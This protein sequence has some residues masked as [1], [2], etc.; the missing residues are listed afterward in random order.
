MA[1]TWTLSGTNAGLNQF[2]TYSFDVQASE[3]NQVRIRFLNDAYN[4]DINYDRNVLLDS[5]TLNGVTY[6]ANADNVFVAGVDVVG[7][8]ISNGYLQSNRVATNGFWEFNST[9]KEVGSFI[10]LNVSGNTGDEEGLLLINGEAVKHFG[11]IPQSG[12]TV[13]Y[14]SE[15]PVSIDQLRVAF[16]ND[17][18]S[19]TYDRNLQ[20]NRLVLDGTVYTA[21][22]PQVF[23]TGY[24]IEGRGVVS[25][26]FQTNRLFANGYFQFRTSDNP[27]DP[28]PSSSLEQGLIGFWTLDEPDAGKQQTDFS[29]NGNAAT[30]VNVT[31]P[32]GPTTDKATSSDRNGGSFRF[33]GIDDGLS[34]STNSS[35][36]LSSGRYTQALWV[37]P[38]SG[39]DVYRGIIGFQPD[40]LAGGRYPFI[41]QKGTALYAGFGT[42]GDTWK[43]VIANNV[44]PIGQWSHVAVTFDGSEMELYVN[45]K[46]VAF[47]SSFAGSLPTTSVSQLSIG[48]I[49]TAFAGSVDEVRLYN[50]ALTEGEVSQL[51]A[52]YLGPDDSPPPSDNQSSGSIGFAKT[53]QTV[54][55]S[56]GSVSVTFTRI[57]GARGAAKA[58]F[59]TEDNSAIEG[60]DYIGQS[61]GVVEFADGQTESTVTIPIFD[62]D[63]R[64]GDRFFQ[65][66]MFRVEGAAQGQPRTSIVT[67]VDNESG[68]GLIGRWRLDDSNA[69]GSIVDSSG[70]ALNGTG[71]GFTA[72]NGASSDAPNTASGNGGS[73]RF[74]GINDAISIGPSESL[75]L[76]SGRYS[77]SLWIKPTHNDNEF[78]GIIG[79]QQ[80][81]S[82][83]TRYPFVYIRGDALYA[84]FGTGGNTWKGVVSGNVVTRNA[85]NHI[86]VTFDGSTMILFVN[87]EEVGRN[88]DFGGSVP[89]TQLA[90]LDIGRIN[91]Q[92][93]GAIDD[94]QLYD[95]A[96]SGSEVQNLID[97]ATLPPPRFSGFF[98]AQP[99]A[100]GLREPTGLERLPDGRF[101]AS[102]RA[103]TIRVINTDGSV[104]SRP[105]LDISS[106]VNRVGADR[107]I[108]AIAIPPDFATTRQLYVAYT[109]DPPE[110]QG[111]SGDG[112]PDGEGGRVARLSRFTL[113]EDFT[114]ADPNSEVVVLG[115]NSLYQY[116]G[117]PNR[118]PLLN[119]PKSGVDANGNYIED[120]IA[121]DELSHTIGDIEFGADGSLYVA[122]GDGG[123]YGRV[124]PVNLRALD[125]NSLN[126]KILRI[127]PNTGQGLADNPFYDGNPNSNRSRVYSLGLRNP[128][129]FAVQPQTNEI[130]ISDVGWL[131]WEEI[132]TGRGKNF[133][134]PVFEGNGPTGGSRGS[135]GSLPEVQQY[136]ATNPN[137]TGPLWTRSHSSGARAIIMGDFVSGGSYPASLQGAFL[138]TDIGDQVLRAG[139]LDASGKLI[140]VIPVSAKIGFI[141]D[142]M[143]MPDGSLYYTDLVAGTLGRLVYNA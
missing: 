9:R 1:A 104:N 127:D 95:R 133:G 27:T 85:W 31:A 70:N 131:N 130:Y 11:P 48:R 23:T 100:R 26:N 90:Q 29:G 102:E 54:N 123:S 86:A 78:R 8:G 115:K 58:F 97:G 89:T 32:A 106:Q 122:V 109:Y 93:I 6:Q 64:D 116:I 46:S 88:S 49:N 56:A 7:R 38:T 110:V 61:E 83:G 134:W 45:G 50:R 75:R 142:I 73:I 25:G 111:R 76:T 105:L 140:D 84:G 126:G 98:T 112:G 68:G 137:T 24:F 41:Y 17:F 52:G 63:Q 94:V 99:L 60:R 67:V 132:N 13:A 55:E 30:P 77:Q 20:V 14:Q 19:G 22:D 107:G 57:G 92:F 117:Q 43:G 62:N 129:R 2:Q 124:D 42:G 136:L 10:Q 53:Q 74:D 12:L 120:F 139:R 71:T 128:F 16:I 103:G 118:R 15:S 113:N 82:V 138:F 51:A 91:N 33:D 125:V 18:V 81:D 87:G 39:A 141:T 135:Y 47:N 96:I 79:Y 101:L 34:I 72:P 5:V 80:G 35:L 108:M 21:D 65:L 40:R 69:N 66:S 28:P 121:S 4:P 44:L 37:K 36:T 114:S 143:R 119:D 3:I 59:Q